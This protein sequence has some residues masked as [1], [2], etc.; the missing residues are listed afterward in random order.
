VLFDSS[1]VGA[2]IDFERHFGSERRAAV[3][4]QDPPRALRDLRR[5]FAPAERPQRRIRWPARRRTRH[6][7]RSFAGLRRAHGGRFWSRASAQRNEERAARDACEDRS[8]AHSL[9]PVLLG[10]PTNRAS[11]R[12]LGRA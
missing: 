6:L 1:D 10:R 3:L 11:L 8:K 4:V 5:R 2:T 12:R 7:R 9:E